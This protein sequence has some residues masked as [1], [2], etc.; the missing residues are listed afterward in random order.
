LTTEEEMAMGWIML[1]K[2]GTEYGPCKKLN[3]G[4]KDCA[5]TRAEAVTPCRWCG[6]EIGY[7]TKFYIESFYTDD[8]KL[9]GRAYEHFL[10]AHV[11]AERQRKA[12]GA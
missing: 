6:K 11:G 8:G 10:C 7:E 3:C 1:S 4:H 2:P 9:C 12:V 5:A